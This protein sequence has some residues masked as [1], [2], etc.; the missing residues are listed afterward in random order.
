MN[1]IVID[2]MTRIEGHLR[3]EAFVEDGKVIKCR[4]SGTLFRGFE[5]FLKGRDPRDAQRITQRV[6]GVC[7]AAH[8]IASTLNLDSAFGIDDKIPDNAR[9]IRNLILGSNFIQSHVLHF[10]HLAALDYVDVTS[11]ADYSGNNSDLNRVKSFLD[12]GHLGPFVP[13]Y[14]GDYRLSKEANITAVAHYVEALKIRRLAHEMLAMFGG[15]MPHSMAVVPGGVTCSPT[16]DKI[17]GF[18]WRLNRCR[19]FIDNIYLS[20]VLAVAEA[21]ADYF[22]IGRGCDHWISYGVFDQETE[23]KNLTQR[24]RLIPSGVVN[25]SLVREALDPEKIAEDVRH[26][27]FEGERRKPVEGRTEPNPGKEA[28]YS[29]I[30][31]P[32]YDEKVAEV[33]PLARILNAYLAGD[34]KIKNLV[35]RVLEKFHAKPDALFSVLGRHAARAIECK[36]VAD[37]MAE[38]VLQLKPGGP[39]YVDYQLPEEAEGMGLSE[40]PR[41]ALGHWITIKDKKI[42]HY[43][44]VVP[45]TWN[46]SPKDANGQ[47]GPIEQAILDTKVKDPENPFEIVRIVRSFDPC[48]ACA[49][50]L[51]D[52]RGDEIGRHRIV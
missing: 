11:V 17:T 26:S 29:W 49:V 20:D 51:I 22:E 46:A 37:A 52:A 1:K 50:H 28:A 30:K 35:D 38:W 14:E 45:T 25:S 18:L 19:D 32:R 39:V 48:L 36:F 44:M 3:I 5:I 6:C 21:Y 41:G 9:I 10:Y 47:P 12:R 16:T 13:R 31:A 40:A 33:G 7:P 2:P 27:W 24:E 43:Q 15:K 23:E 34:A 42:D 4:S 8:S